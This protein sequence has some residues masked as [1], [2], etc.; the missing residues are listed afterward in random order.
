M[1]PLTSIVTA[2][3]AGA[4]AGLN[5]TVAQAVKDGYAALKARI[6]RKYA[7]VDIDLLEQNPASDEQRTVVKE[8]LL[9]TGAATDVELLRTAKALLDAIQ[10]QAVDG[11]GPIGVDLKEIKA[12]SLTIDDIMAAGTGVKIEGAEVA[13]DV[14]IRQVR[15]GGQ[16]GTAPNP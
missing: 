3:A 1:D 11:S 14:T 9:K 10:S 13:G 12:A 7:A 6:R 8:E 15:A 2:L 4:A 5:S 16:R